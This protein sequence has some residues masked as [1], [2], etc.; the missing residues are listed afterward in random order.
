M[1]RNGFA[2]HRDGLAQ[3]ARGAGWSFAMHRTDRSPATALLALYA[4]L[5]PEQAWR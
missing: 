2:L 4:A 3:I 1:A 5:A